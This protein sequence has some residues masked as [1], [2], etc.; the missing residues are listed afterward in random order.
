MDYEK[1]AYEAGR[2]KG[3]VEMVSIPTWKSE[4]CCEKRSLVQ[5]RKVNKKS[6]RGSVGGEMKKIAQGVQL[7]QEKSE[8]GKSLLEKR[9]VKQGR[10]SN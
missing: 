3:R 7:G 1:H 8:G 6:Q 4:R 5:T 2:G 9:D 10:V